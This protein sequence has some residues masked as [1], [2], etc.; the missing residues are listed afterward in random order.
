MLLS[1]PVT[2]INKNQK[3]GKKHYKFRRQ[4]ARRSNFT[5]HCASKY[6]QKLEEVQILTGMLQLV[7]KDCLAQLVGGGGGGEE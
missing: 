3:K 5:W 1:F 7:K 4:F 6:I 2:K